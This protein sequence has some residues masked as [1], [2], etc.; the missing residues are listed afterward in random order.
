LSG[1]ITGAGV[2]RQSGSG[3]L[4]LTGTNTSSGSTF[5]N[6]GTLVVG[7]GGIITNASFN[8]IGQ[9]TGDNATLNLQGNGS[10]S[11][12]S[13]F[14]AGDINN[15]IGTVNISGTA[16]LAANAIFLG[17]ANGT[18]S[19][20]SGTLN[21]TNGAVSTA[22]N[23]DFIFVIAGRNSATSAGLGVY[24]LYGGTLNVNNGGNAWIGGYGHGTMNVSG[25]TATFSGYVSVGRQVN[26]VGSLTISGG[27]VSQTNTGSSILVGESGTGTLTVTNSGQLTVLGSQLLLGNTGS[28]TVNLGGGV[29]TAP[30]VVKG[31]GT[32]TFNFNGGTLKAN[33]ASTTFMT[34]LTAANVLVGGAVIDDGGFAITI[35]Q[36]LLVGGGGLT[37]QGGG[38]LTLN[39]GNTFTG[40]LSIG[41]GTLTIGGAGQLGSGTYAGNITNAATFNY[42]SSAAQ[43]LSG[44][45]SGSGTLQQSG[46]GTLTLTGVN[47]YSGGTSLNG[48]ILNLANVQALGA[49]GNTLTYNAG[50]TNQL[51]TDTAFG[52]ANPVYKVNVTGSSSYNGTMVLNRATAGAL[53]GI[54]HNFGLLT[55]SLNNVNGGLNVLAGANAPT[56][57]AVDSLAFTG[58]SYGNWYSVSETIA[59]IG[60]NVSLG[61]VTPQA[62]YGTGNAV[63]TLVLDGTSANNQITGIISDNN[64]GAHLN[65]AA[66]T[67][68]NSSTW[69]LSGANTY[70][71]KTTVGGGTLLVNNSSGSGTGAGNLAVNSGGT[72]GGTG[73][74]SGTVTVSSGGTLR[75][76]TG[77]GNLGTL[78][79][80]AS[81]TLNGQIWA[82]IYKGNSPS[83][84]EVVVSSL[85]M[86]YGGTLMVSNNP[87]SPVLASGDSFTLFNGSGY[88]GWFSSVTVPALTSGISWDTNKL[89]TSGV[90][91]IYPFTTTALALSTPTNSAAVIPA[92]KLANHAISSRAGAAYPTGWTATATTPGNGTASVDGSGNL[93]YTPNANFS[94][95]DSFTLTFQDG[96]GWQT[97][98][99]SVTVGSGNSVGAN[100]TFVGQIGSDFVVTFAGIP[101][102]LYTVETNS[103]MTGAGWTKEFNPDPGAVNGNYTPNAG[104]SFSITN[105]LGEP[106]L[107]LRTV[108]PAY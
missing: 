5:V 92:A 3:T 70:T 78:A 50:A 22:G 11:T 37:K 10:F 24:N 101:G 54:T 93:T 82:E 43:T 25:G 38:T 52:G 44:I 87:A 39:G 48:G 4:T 34:G 60:A 16:T 58:L 85:P 62:S 31:S 61:T 57:G 65:Q 107:Y 2:F 32:G 28:G 42:A 95:S 27:V 89:A 102:Y 21:Q 91:D 45:I 33:S 74:I 80:G 35:G 104:G 17:S 7:T 8:D 77:V 98:V 76:G 9:T 99:V 67:K 84:D 75:A 103:V 63:Q 46:L 97:M 53:T 66:I 23:G 55:I 40:N 56:G 69:T 12:T 14:N 105:N 68:T 86:T 81:P 1:N 72:L 79:L 49:T 108:Y 96:H 88:S 29:I 100:A 90:L 73:T 26:S 71:G 15:S 30:K 106:S 94:G 19:T 6:A 51:S 36:P 13:D 18:G 47:T 41:G 20:A 64:S 59:P 83:A